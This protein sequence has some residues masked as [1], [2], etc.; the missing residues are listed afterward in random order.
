MTFQNHFPKSVF[1]LTFLRAP[2]ENS[3]NNVHSILCIYMNSDNT[4]VVRSGPVCI[5]LHLQ[6]LTELRGRY[7]HTMDALIFLFSV[8][9]HALLIHSFS[10]QHDLLQMRFL[11]WVAPPYWHEKKDIQTLIPIYSCLNSLKFL[12]YVCSS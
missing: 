3:H 2:Q 7:G 9:S 8:E 12:V 10:M 4:Y 11:I 5:Y 1:F 6:I